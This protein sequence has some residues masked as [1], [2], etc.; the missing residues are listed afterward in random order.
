M[1]IVLVDGDKEDEPID[2]ICLRGEAGFCDL[3]MCDALVEIIEREFGVDRNS[4]VLFLNALDTS[5]RLSASGALPSV[6]L[7]EL[8]VM[9]GCTIFVST[10]PSTKSSSRSFRIDGGSHQSPPSPMRVPTTSTDPD[11][12]FSSSSTKP[13]SDVPTV[14]SALRESIRRFDGL[15]LDRVIHQLRSHLNI[16]V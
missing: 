1:E 10:T 8:G 4:Q 3:T 14:V 13:I 2:H 6:S 15:R 9:N 11:S 12:S 5:C 7:S 16:D